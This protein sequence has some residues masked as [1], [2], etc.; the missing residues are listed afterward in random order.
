[1]L[2]RKNDCKFAL[3]WNGVGSVGCSC[4][5]VCVCEYVSMWVC[6]R[7]RCLVYNVKVLPPSIAVACMPVSQQPTANSREAKT[8]SLLPSKKRNG[9]AVE[10]LF[11][12]AKIATTPKIKTHLLR[13]KSNKETSLSQNDFFHL[14]F[15]FF[16]LSPAETELLCGGRSELFWWGQKERQIS[17][18]FDVFLSSFFLSL[19]LSF[20]LSSSS[21]LINEQR[22][23]FNLEHFFLPVMIFTNNNNTTSLQK[24]LLLLPDVLLLGLEWVSEWEWVRKRERK[25]ERERGRGR[26][27]EGGR[28][29]ER[30]G[31]GSV[32]LRQNR[33]SP[34]KIQVDQV[35]Q[36]PDLH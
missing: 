4:F 2:L 5:C 32:L 9:I 18:L 7:R 11:L 28:E 31:E 16:F 20:F 24:L 21:F 14:F 6:G 19:S 17:Q 15:F 36:Q 30:E 23:K 35:L 34:T 13:Y 12:S 27:R 3:F 10:T 25:R 26:E 29:R 1:M 22:S 33:R 8:R